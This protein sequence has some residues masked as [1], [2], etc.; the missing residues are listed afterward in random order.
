[1]SFNI[2][3]FNVKGLNTPY[4]R[5]MEWKEALRLKSEVI[6]FQETHFI[7]NKPPAFHHPKYPHVLLANGPKKQ[8]GMAIAIKDSNP[9]NQLETH[10]DP[11]G[12]FI[13]LICELYKI[14]YTL[15]NIYLPNTHQIRF[16]KKIWK[17]V[18]SLKQGHVIL[19]GDFNVIP[20]KE[21]DLSNPLRSKQRRATL[22]QF[23][24]SSNLFDVWRCQH[25]TE[26]DFTIFSNVH[27][28]Y[29]RIDL[30]LVDK[31]M[32]QKIEKSNIHVITLS[33]HA[34]ISISVGDQGIETRANRWRYDI[35][36]LSHQENLKSIRRALNEY[37]EFNADSVEDPF[38]LW[39][40]HKV[41]IRGLLIQMN[42]RLK[43][44]QRKWLN[45]L[46]TTI[47]NFETS[48][49]QNTTQKTR[50]SLYIARQELRTLLISRQQNR[51]C[52]LKA[53]SYR[54]RETAG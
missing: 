30:F 47:Q 34:P 36:T 45:D 10:L 49:K 5:Q 44:Q 53:N 32:L 12:R 21:L 25:S 24:A 23:L 33:D 8:G 4:K 38:T 1:M 35:F 9:F 18:E 27:H 46:L 48:N 28:T 13:I 3:S 26:R 51:L 22:S 6:C 29:S 7:S 15:V 20:N 40:A 14:K 41:Y 43:R 52:A 19:T 2:T 50:D 11:S 16:L 37:F 39:N 42:S 17:K 31:F 54:C